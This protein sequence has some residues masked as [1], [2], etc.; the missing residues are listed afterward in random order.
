MKI[1]VIGAGYVGLTTAACL[2]QIGH[3]VFCSESDVDKLTKLQNG[4]MPLF[5]PNL[6]KIIQG[7]RK[8]GRLRFGSTEEGIDWGRAIFICVGTPPLPNGDADL[9][10]IEGVARTIA[11][12][13]SGYRLIIEK[14]TVPVQTGSQLRKHLSVHCTRG[15]D[16]DVASNP[17]FLRE[18]TAVEDF[19]HPDRIV[20]GVDSSRAEELLREI[21]EP[22]IRQSFQCPVHADCPKTKH[23][24][25]LTTDTSSA[26]LIKHASNSFLAMKISFINMVANLCEM[27][28]ADVTKVAEGM[29]L[30]PRIGSA[31]LN[32][33]I[34]FGG[35]C[36]PKDVQAFIRIAEK[37]G[38]DF[39]LLKEVEK[40]NQR[41]IH[42]FVEKV[43]NELW[44][45]RGKKIAVWG[46]AFKPNT[47]DVRFAPSITLIKS[48]LDEGAIVSAYDPEATEKAKT[49]LPSIAYCKDPYQAA[50]G[51]DAVLIV[52]EWEEFGAI[53]W[54]RLGS[55]VERRLIID[56]R[57]MFD[58]PDVTAH[59]F[60]Y[61]SIGR[62]PAL[63]APKN[64]Q[65]PDASATLESDRVLLPDLPA[66][67]NRRS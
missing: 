45:L 64:S 13:A 50:Q 25:F 38:C 20:V 15:L 46:L 36:F 53:D 35:F 4:V 37:S 31:F 55:I 23:P 26:E 66:L 47:D 48:L 29:G 10:A 51:A 67:V 52:T 6:E 14:S 41:R 5:E 8:S 40:I 56:G 49:L 34:G 19:L 2:A 24:I 65:V 39:S 22:V 1:S 54:E 59:G 42:D 58:A 3:D 11:K 17:E 44:V 27:V 16:Y 9:C 57:N 33:G 32:P 63:S 12:R 62:P 30:D 18:G 7:S 61:L 43:R 21:Y 28:G 60:H